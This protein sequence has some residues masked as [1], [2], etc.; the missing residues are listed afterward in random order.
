MTTVL[1]LI[2]L[3]AFV[4]ISIG[5]FKHSFDRRRCFVLPDRPELSY[6]MDKRMYFL[7]FVVCTAPFFLAQFALIKYLVYF[8]FIL[9][10]MCRGELTLK[11]ESITGSYLLF[12]GWLVVSCFYGDF[13]YNS[14]SLL[15]K[16]MLP[17]LSLWLGYSAI[18]NKYDLYFFSKSVTKCAII[19]AL[20]I[21]G[22]CL[23]LAKALYYA[24]MGT[25]VFL[26]YAGFADYLTSLFVLPLVLW[27]MTG[28][29][30]YLWGA[31]CLLASPVLES[32][33]TGIGGI[34]IVCCM[35]AFFRYKVKSIPVIALMGVLFLSGVLFVPQ[36]NKKF[37]GDDAG[38]VSANDIWEKDAL[39]LDKVNTSGRTALWDLALE[40]F[41]APNPMC[42]AG[43]G[44]VTKFIK[45][46]GV[47]E[48]TIALLHSDYVQIL[49]DNGLVGIILI[50]IF[51][52]VVLFKVFRYTWWHSDSW[53]K[54]TGVMA[55][56]SLS[57]VAFSM[58]FDNVVSHSMTSMINP[59]IFIGFFLKFVDLF[60]HDKLS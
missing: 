27:W 60:Q 33:R 3:I 6:R 16:Y 39:S 9:W 22:F 1:N 20:F 35:F 59:F 32:V 57:G 36:V 45:E 30:A 56:A 48:H 7:L 34:V 15:V 40:K 55:A 11:F 14:F 26:M 5:I 37:F 13:S 46:R 47:K 19:Y 25:G 42:G 49:C 12:Y 4:C 54:I 8:L 50:S 41:Y 44:E 29:K 53:V 58:G 2:L 24:I 10:L 23:F 18:D 21:G 52:A 43:L 51:F 28:R 31:L 38:K 17:L